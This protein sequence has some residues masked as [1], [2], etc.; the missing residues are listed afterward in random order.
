MPTRPHRGRP[1]PWKWGAIAAS[2]A[3]PLA[4][5]LLAAPAPRALAGDCC[6]GE[7]PKAESKG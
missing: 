5:A 1:S 6:S 2:V 7:E 4:A 3:L